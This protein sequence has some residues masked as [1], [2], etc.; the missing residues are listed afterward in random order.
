QVELDRIDAILAALIKALLERGRLDP[1]RVEQLLP[2]AAA[3]LEARAAGEAAV[4]VGPAVDKY[5][6]A[7]PPDLD[8]AS[9]LP[10]YHG[11][12][13]RLVF[14]LSFQDLDEGQVRW[15]YRRP[16]Q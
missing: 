5:G 8:C 14:A 15:D 12:C 9:L 6:V 7:S 4:D 1:A 10:L 16:Y 11:R 3:R 13:C 2:D